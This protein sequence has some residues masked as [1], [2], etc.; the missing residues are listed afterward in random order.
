MGYLVNLYNKCLMF[1][2]ISLSSTAAALATTCE[3]VVK[4]SEER[5]NLK[6]MLVIRDIGRSL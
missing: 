2:Y 5:P 6:N 4:E 1:Q 3:A